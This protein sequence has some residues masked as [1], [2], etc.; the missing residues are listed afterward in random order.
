LSQPSSAIDGRETKLFRPK[1]EVVRGEEEPVDCEFD[2]LFV[3]VEPQV[4]QDPHYI[5]RANPNFAW[6]ADSSI[7]VYWEEVT[8]RDPVKLVPWSTQDV[9]DL[10]EVDRLKLP[11]SRVGETHSHLLLTCFGP[12][13]ETL[14]RKPVL[15]FDR[16]AGADVT[17]E[18]ALCVGVSGDT[19]EIW[20]VD[21]YWATVESHVQG[22][23]GILQVIAVLPQGE[24][25][26]AEAE[27]W[28]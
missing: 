13:A 17:R 19:H 25:I 8:A 1:V 4:P 5:W 23:T 2:D 6:Q 10:L 27:A 18:D 28:K 26:G 12:K 9:S 20:L 21:R 7:L 16:A 22:T 3:F 14:C 15:S 11:V 24:S